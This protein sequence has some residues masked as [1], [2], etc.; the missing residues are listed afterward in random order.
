MKRSCYPLL[1]VCLTLFACTGAPQPVATAPVPE[2][3]PEQVDRADG[4]TLYEGLCA[5]CHGLDARGG[6][7]VAEAL[8]VPMPDLT[9]LSER[10]DGRFP[11]ARVERSIRGPET[12]EI[13]GGPQM[14][15]WGPALEGVFDHLPHVNREAFAANRIRRLARYLESLQVAGE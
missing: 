1:S 5:S 11:L 6:G 2:I 12:L 7:P 15:L 10:N 3:A 4:R 8:S 14:P 13:H 9:R